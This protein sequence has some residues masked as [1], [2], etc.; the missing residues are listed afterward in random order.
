MKSSSA[1]VA[2]TLTLSRGDSKSGPPRGMGQE[3]VDALAHV[4]L[5]ANVSKRHLRKVV[6]L[7]REVRVASGDTVIFRT[8]TGRELFVILDGTAV[9]VP[10][11]GA[12]QRLG[13]GDFFGEMAL[14]DGEP[15]SAAVRAE[16]DLLLMGL[17][18]EQF[19][20]LLRDEPSI[21]HAIILELTARVRRLEGDG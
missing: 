14:L 1:V 10:R 9:V 11:S 15:R 16:R 2:R 5:F 21:A 4:P 6:R 12:E 18:R 19:R 13:R 3:W 8:H 17:G 7:A 20:K